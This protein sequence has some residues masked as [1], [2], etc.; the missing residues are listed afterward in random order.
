MQ[1]RAQQDMIVYLLLN[2]DSSFCSNST[3]ITLQMCVQMFFF[4]VY[5]LSEDRTMTKKFSKE[6]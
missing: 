2:A 6:L 1:K 5:R 4:F 3:I